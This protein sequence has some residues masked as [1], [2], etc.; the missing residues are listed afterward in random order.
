[1]KRGV[2][3]ASWKAARSSPIDLFITDSVTETSD[4]TAFISSLFVI[5]APG[6]SAR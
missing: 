6:L 1:M 3:D 4:H 5:S 2:F